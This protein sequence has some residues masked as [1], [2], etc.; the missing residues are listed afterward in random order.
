MQDTF[1]NSPLVLVV[2]A[3]RRWTL[4]PLAA[5]ADSGDYRLVCWGCLGTVIAGGLSITPWP[6]G[7]EG[8]EEHRA[9]KRKHPFNQLGEK[10]NSSCMNGLLALP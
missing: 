8:K 10:V 2:V 5:L 7:G 6:A 1:R 3:K 4:F 9:L